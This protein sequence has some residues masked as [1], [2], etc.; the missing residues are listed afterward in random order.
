MLTTI[1]STVQV[2]NLT[3]RV[4]TT[5]GPDTARSP[6][7]LVHGLGMTHRYLDRLRGELAAD[8]VVHSIDL[9]GYGPDSQP[10]RELGVEDHAALIGEALTAL[11]ITSCTLVGHSMGVQFV[12]AVALQFPALAERIVLIGPVVDRRRRTVL[13][14]AISLG[15][16]TLR[17]TPSA[18]FTVYTDYL[19]TGMRWYLRQLLPMMEYP[20]ER[21]VERVQC[22]VLVVRGGRDP[23]AR[24]RWCRELA[25]RARF[26]SFL[27]IEGQP[28]V[29]QHSAARAVADGIIAFRG[30]PVPAGVPPLPEASAWAMGK[31]ED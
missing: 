14:Q 17:E 7:V 27:E 29:V 5:P 19:R 24:R 15:H 30:F 18:N 21:A 31:L 8:A 2:D 20:L 28:H 4:L 3:V 16:D 26:G 10:R 23:V 25:E 11:G 12:T 1:L 9:P 13:Q 6:Y 22:P